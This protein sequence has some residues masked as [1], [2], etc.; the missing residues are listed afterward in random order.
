MRAIKSLWQCFMMFSRVL[1]KLL[2]NSLGSWF[3]ENLD[4]LLTHIAHFDKII[5]LSSLVFNTFRSAFS[6]FFVHVKQYDTF[7]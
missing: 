7:Y 4:F 2:Y 5:V 3:L 6:V 1:L